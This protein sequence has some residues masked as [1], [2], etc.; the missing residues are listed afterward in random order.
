MILLSLLI[1]FAGT[2]KYRQYR[3]NQVS[4]PK[5]TNSIIKVGIDDIYKSLV[6]N[7]ISNP[8]F[9]FKS[10]LKK[11]AKSKF[12]GLEH[13]LKI[14]AS[15]YLYTI[16]NQ[17]K[18]A[19]FSRLEIKN[20]NTFENFLRNVLQFKIEKKSEGLNC[21]KSKPGNI[22]IYYNSKHAAFV[23]SNESA[24]F[25]LILTD[26]LNQKNFIELNKS[27]FNAVKKST[28]HLAMSDGEHFAV[29]N[30]DN[31][32]INFNDEFFS[33]IIIPAEKPLYRQISNQSAISFWLNADFRAMPKR[34]L[35]LKNLSL[36]RD[37]LIRYYKG[38][39]DF[40]WINTVQQTDSVITYD[41][42]DDFEKVEKVAL[43]KREIPNIVVNVSADARGLK[44]YLNRKN[45]INLDSNVINKS[46]FPLYNVFV[47]GDDKQLILSTGKYHK[48][49]TTKVAT[50]DFFSL[51]VNFER[52]NKQITLPILTRYFSSLTFLEIKGKAIGNGKISMNG[53]L[54]M[55]NKDINSLYQ[56]FKGL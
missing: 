31:G 53:K 8:G 19:L 18:T 48:F 3:A 39:A 24:D 2:F 40:E 55:K 7:M 51:N 11:D 15:I 46:V 45:I 30:F 5:N 32:K 54:E 26:I 36:E 21:A 50:R 41:Y 43:Q 4:I 13:G 47:G 14:P 1:F 34:T 56:L 25:E 42:N 10:D 20:L 9:Y 6:G 49:D 12:D 33:K 17:P 23:V 52:L 35:K 22:A 38:Y 28:D 29:L 27:N 16:Q 44:N 37:S